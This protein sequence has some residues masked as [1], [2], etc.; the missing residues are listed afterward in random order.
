[1]IVASLVLGLLLFLMS[2]TGGYF[3]K[4]IALVSYFDNAEGLRVGAPVRL[5]GVD[6]GNVSKILI[7]RD[8]DKQ[9]TPVEI[10]MKV[11]TKYS[12]N[13]RRDTRTSLA[14]AGVLGET[15]MDMDSSQAVGPPA[16]DGDTLP[17]LIHPD[18]NEVVRSSQSTLQ[19][20][21]AL[22]KR[23]DRILAFAESGKGSLGKLIYDPTLYDRL[24]ETVAELKTVVDE[25]AKGQGSLGQLI[26]SNDAYNKFVATLDKMNGVVDDLQQGKGTAGKFL[27]DPTLYD[28][29]NDT[30]AN[31]KKVS[32]DLNAGKGTAGRLLKDEEL[33]K[34]IDTTMT[35]LAALT[36]ELEAGQGTAGKLF[37]DDTLYNNLNQML[38]ESRNLVKAIRENPKKYLSI[39]LHVF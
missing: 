18:F 29:A 4:R 26:N 30:I 38:E 20:M 13:L 2:G 11:S 19:N 21:D 33:G 22:L 32:E 31:L 14:T 27:K 35:K 3:T 6:I 36:S 34:K 28:N 7:V 16:Q 17:T 39:K 37:K 10:V 12:F 15:F 8:R 1:V 23:A 9:L 24:S 25:I 5:S